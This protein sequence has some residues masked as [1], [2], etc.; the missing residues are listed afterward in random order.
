MED[1]FS[2]EMILVGSIWVVIIF[3][4][5]FIVYKNLEPKFAEVI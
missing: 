1:A 3:L 4:L 5:G 2:A